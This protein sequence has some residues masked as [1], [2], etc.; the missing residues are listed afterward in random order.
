MAN[1]LGFGYKKVYNKSVK[2]QI[3]FDLFLLYQA[4]VTEML[5]LW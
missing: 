5:I 3:G 1:L 4:N 2:I